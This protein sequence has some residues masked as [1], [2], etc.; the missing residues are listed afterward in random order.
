MAI[1][2]IQDTGGRP[3]SVDPAAIM[4]ELHRRYPEGGVESFDALKRDN[5][6]IPW[7]TLYNKSKECFGDTLTKHLKTEGILK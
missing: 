3:T 1:P 2:V 7:K 6:D 5:P 4:A